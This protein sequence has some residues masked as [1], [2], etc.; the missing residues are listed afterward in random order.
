MQ[1]NRP[2]DIL[3]TYVHV[4][5]GNRMAPVDAPDSFWPELA[6]GAFP[7]LDQGRLLS[8]FT[9]SSAWETWER[10]PAGEELVLLL[11]GSVTIL[12]EAP[13]GQRRIALAT[14]GEYVLVPPG[15]W[16]T[17]TTET[18]STLLFLTPGVGTEHRP[19]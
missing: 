16:H 4:Q 11:S 10:H 17:A 9:F 6:A 14:A 2:S 3:R 1:A 15:V 7:K 13:E 12:L 19:V 5:D 8:A 18:E